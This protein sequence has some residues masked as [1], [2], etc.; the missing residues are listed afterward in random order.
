LAV[1]RADLFR[2]GTQSFRLSRTALATLK[3]A[4]LYGIYAS[5]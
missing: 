1:R 4:R 3:D 2:T 5:T